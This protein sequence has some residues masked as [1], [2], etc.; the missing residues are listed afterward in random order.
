MFLTDFYRKN[1]VNAVIRADFTVF[2]AVFQCFN[3]F[4]QNGQK[5]RGIYSLYI[6]NIDSTLFFSIYTFPIFF[7][8]LTEYVNIRMGVPKNAVI[9]AFFTVFYTMQYCEL[10]PF[11]VKINLTEFDRRSDF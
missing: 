4:G 7:D 9:H 11:S 1:N 6:E 3:S 8:R 5:N 2:T 10:T